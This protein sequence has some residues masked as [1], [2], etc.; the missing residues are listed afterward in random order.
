[1]SDQQLFTINDLATRDDLQ[2]LMELQALIFGDA[3][4]NHVSLPTL[5]SY[6]HNGQHLLGVF[7]E[8]QL[9]GYL[10]AYFGTYNRDTRRPAMANL[11]LVLERLGVHPD[12]RNIGL[13]TELATQLRE[14]ARKQAVRVITTAFSPLNSRMAYLLVRK[15][16]AVIQYYHPDYYPDAMIDDF[17]TSTRGQ[18]IAEWWVDHNRVEERLFGN[19]KALTLEQYLDVVPIVNPTTGKADLP[20]PTD[21]PYELGSETMLLI[22]I[23]ADYEALEQRDKELAMA[24]C[25][26][27]QPVMFEAFSLGY[28]ATDFLHDIRDGR[29]RSF[30][31]MSY[32]GPQIRFEAEE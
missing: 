16:G 11:K 19:R 25:Q 31:L 7:S 17:V 8:Q 13:G 2:Q 20:L 18:L 15:L 24:W 26:H 14:I 6:S 1:M 9:F 12:Y 5:V 4:I 29:L 21:K 27:I 32:D 23:P 3:P 22:E 30:Y 28:V 10:I